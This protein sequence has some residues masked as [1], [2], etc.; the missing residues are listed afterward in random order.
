M[1]LLFPCRQLYKIT[2]QLYKTPLRLG[3]IELLLMLYL[4]TTVTQAILFD[5][6]A[7]TAKILDGKD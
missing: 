6:E 4:L 3:R 1:P 2:D 5:I 7:S